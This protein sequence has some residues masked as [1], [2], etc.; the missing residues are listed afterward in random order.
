MRQGFT[1]VELMLVLAILGLI[2]V[3]VQGVLV[4]TLSAKRNSAQRAHASVVTDA[5]FRRLNE[6]L[7]GAFTGNESDGPSFTGEADKLELLST[8]DFLGKG[9]ERTASCA[10]VVYELGIND[11]DPRLSR[12]FRG[13]RRPGEAD[14]SFERKELYPWVTDLKFQY[15]RAV[16]NPAGETKHEVKDSWDSAMAGGLPDAVEVELTLRMPDRAEGWAAQDPLGKF[17]AKTYRLVVAIPAGGSEQSTVKS[18]Q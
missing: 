8:V 15:V 6:D 2:L 13:E 11:A 14:K 12:L 7:R 5:L 9:S 10:R 4:R 16:T 17:L 18:E 3:A 1:L